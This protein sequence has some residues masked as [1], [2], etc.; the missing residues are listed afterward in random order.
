MTGGNLPEQSRGR[1]AT[2]REAGGLE[3]S[4]ATPQL[5]GAHEAADMNFVP[6]PDRFHFWD[7]LHDDVKA[8]V[9]RKVGPR[10]DWWADRHKRER[11]RPYA[12]VLGPNGLAVTT[13]RVNAQGQ[14]T[15]SVRLDP[16][17]PSSLKHAVVQQQPTKPRGALR[18]LVP[19]RAGTTPGPSAPPPQLNLTQD[20][21]G[22]LG[23]LPLE[24]QHRLQTPFLGS[25]P[26]KHYLS[27]AYGTD[28]DYDA[29]CYLAG[30]HTVTFASGHCTRPPGTPPT[31]ATWHLTCYQ[32]DIAR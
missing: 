32:A 7:E 12:V 20:M 23:N 29:W 26:V 24:A 4:T 8:Y 21:R 18:N 31:Q 1:P 5:P 17:V 25:Q 6:S 16:F 15:Q 11:D 10:I 2:R 3:R 27:Y 30:T 19:G 9:E 28:E 22:F 14:R 13:P